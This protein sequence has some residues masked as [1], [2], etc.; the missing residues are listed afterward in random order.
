[1]KENGSGTK[2]ILLQ[3]D[4]VKAEEVAGL[5]RQGLGAPAGE[6][7]EALLARLFQTTDED[8]DA[9]YAALLRGLAPALRLYPSTSATPSP[10]RPPP[11]AATSTRST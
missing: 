10:S 2:E 6:G 11:R 9:Q 8:F 4:P 3:L 1:M 7:L 5:L